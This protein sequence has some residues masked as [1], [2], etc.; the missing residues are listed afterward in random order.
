MLV[1]WLLSACG[2][3]ERPDGHDDPVVGP[4]VAINEVSASNHGLVVDAGGATPDW[5]ELANPTAA[6]VPLGG[7]TLSDDPDDPQKWEFPDTVLPAGGYLL[8]LASGD[9]TSGVAGAG[10]EIRTSFS[11]DSEGE[12]V[13]LYD[14]SGNPIDEATP[15]PMSEDQS[16]GRKPDGTGPW[17]YFLAPTPGAANT[18]ESRLGFA[19]A[20]A[21]DPPGGFYPGGVDVRINGGSD[22]TVRVSWDAAEPD[23]ADPV[24]GDTV[25]IPSS[26]EVAVLGARAF[27]EGLWPG[28]VTTGT[29]LVRAPDD[30][31]VVAITTD[32]ANLWDDETGIYTFGTSYESDLPYYG[33]N[34]WEDW[35]K[36]AQV[37]AWEPDGSLAFSASA[38]LSIHGGWTRAFEQKSL[39]LD[40]DDP[41]VDAVFP[42]LDITSFDRILL[43]AAGNDW[44]G[45]FKG[46]CST[47]AHLRDALMAALASGYDL[48][49]MAFR[50]SE[51]YLNGAWWGI[52]ELREKPDDSY[53][54]EHYGLEDV[55]LLELGAPLE[56]D[57]DAWNTTVAYMRTHD[58]S[59]P[60]NY[61][62]VTAA[63]DVD[64]LATWL[65]FEIFADNT[66]WPGNNVR[67]WRPRTTDGRW[68]WFL[69]DTDFGLGAY[70]ASPE[71]N[72]LAFAL[73]DDGPE[74]PNPPWA[75]EPF[76][77]LFTSPA[78][79][80]TFALRYADLLNTTFDQANT[81]A[82]LEAT[83]DGIAAH[84]G[85][86]VERW[87]TWTDGQT[88]MSMP[89][90]EWAEAVLAID[91]WLEDRPEFARQHVVDQLGLAG[92]FSLSLD[93]DP[94]DGGTFQLA[95]VAVEDGFDGIYFQGIPVTVTAV[96]AAGRTFAGWEDP[97][98]GSATT[99]VV[100][101][102]GEAVALVAR[103]E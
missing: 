14:P 56:G 45:C 65:A 87:G 102:A 73:A 85:R 34:F 88:T 46:G 7:W 39:D 17:G 101:S 37:A 67:W 89:D 2:A 100:N 98:Y 57:A 5:L 40:F 44:H 82:V 43:R 29:Y 83:A 69:Y 3:E 19:P 27:S 103:F 47:G 36:P 54:V 15:G 51:V 50:P 53:L 55:D 33:A 49:A 12:A 96:P 81:T 95:A 75:T 72:T 61:E 38:D 84:M 1:V 60:A 48:D 78:F 99:A 41:I 74:W 63:I 11:L 22:A 6:P 25:P 16:F 86:Q 10:G 79:A 71:N 68:R 24:A 80:Q 9:G 93:A 31:P 62:V 28:P 4:P 26:S 32:P 77:L 97:A 94:P 42:E 66:D 35:K 20:V 91:E 30:L 21:L 18:T 64:E 13:A 70:G 76:R 52:Y 90:G 92:T 8:V 23:E 59:V 58:L